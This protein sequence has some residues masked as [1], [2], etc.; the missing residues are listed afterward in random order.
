MD[1][2]CCN[3]MI[4]LFEELQFPRLKVFS[5]YGCPM[6]TDTFIRLCDYIATSS[7]PHLEELTLGRRSRK[8]E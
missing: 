2:H 8:G 4:D 3:V 6:K 5:L 7:H 1:D